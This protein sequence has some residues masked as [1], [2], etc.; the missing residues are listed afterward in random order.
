MNLKISN[1]LSACILRIAAP[2][3][4]RT[5]KIDRE[6]S[7]N[8]SQGIRGW[9][10]CLYTVLVCDEVKD[11]YHGPKRNDTILYLNNSFFHPLDVIFFPIY[12]QMAIGGIADI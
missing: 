2:G 12:A 7:V 3:G 9:V 6:E 1:F 4:W 11:I 10:G 8:H 5:G